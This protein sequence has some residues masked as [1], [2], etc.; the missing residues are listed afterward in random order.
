MPQQT[1]SCE[2]KKIDGKNY[3][4]Q[5]KL[6]LALDAPKINYQKGDIDVCMTHK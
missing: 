1:R 5:E 6:D 4:R 2:S 3:I